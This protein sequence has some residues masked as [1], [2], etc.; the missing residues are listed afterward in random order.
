[1]S[2]LS[3]GLGP[4]AQPTPLPICKNPGGRR[5]GGNRTLAPQPPMAPPSSPPPVRE[6]AF[7]SPLQQIALIDLKSNNLDQEV[8]WKKG[9]RRRRGVKGGVRM[10]SPLLSPHKFLCFLK[11]STLEEARDIYYLPSFQ[12]S[13]IQM[14][15]P[16]NFICPYTTSSKFHFHLP[17]GP[18]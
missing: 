18:H 17:S 10:E 5:V 11:E 7:L 3:L 9:T 14:P 12:M 6:F 1:M 13:Y 16:R 8:K 2:Q 15:L 4:W